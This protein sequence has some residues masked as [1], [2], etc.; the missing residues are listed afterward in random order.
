MEYSIYIT[1]DKSLE[2]DYCLLASNAYD[3]E[4][5]N[6]NI[7]T[8]GKEKI[9][10]KKLNYLSFSERYYNDFITYFSYGRNIVDNAKIIYITNKSKDEKNTKKENRELMKL[11]KT[12]NLTNR[13]LYIDVGMLTLKDEDMDLIQPLAK[14]KNSLVTYGETSYYH[15]IEEL[16]IVNDIVNDI[17]RRLNKTDFSP[18]EKMLYAYDLIR[19]NY[20]INPEY[21]KKMEKALKMYQEPSY[22][23]SFIY[24]EVL[25]RLKIKNIYSYGDFYQASR[26][27]INIAYVKDEY[28][29]IEGIYYFDIADNSKQRVTNSLM[30]LPD[31][32]LRK[33]LINNYE[34]FCKTKNFMVF[35][36][37]LDIDY[38][39]GDFDEEFMQIY[40]YT[41]EHH[42]IKGVYNLRGLLNNVAQ[43]VDGKPVIDTFKGIQS[44]DEL[45]QIRN[46]TQRFVEL[47]SRDIEGEDFLEMLFN[48]R[49]LEY[50]ENKEL[51]PLNIE[52]LK[53]CL[54]KSNFGFS[55]MNLEFDEEQIYEEE[56]IKEKLDESFETCFEESIANTNMEERIRKLK[57]SLNK[58]I[59]KPKKDDNN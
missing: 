57:L 29:D 25:V 1:L 26:R 52:T 18:I 5:V 3:D 41:F 31:D 10:F 44:D 20:M 17:M 15:N 42:G 9:D 38:S 58:D 4:M 11:I 28:Y 59:N 12:N 39:F 24:K 36:G 33:E 37:S 50:M 34:A 30:N 54:A 32:D 40:D 16:E 51:F 27:A 2:R 7:Y 35:N 19:T 43:F 55:K 8:N 14:C 23:Y 6:L 46:D 13:K 21:E 49:A 45:D 47:F 22:L 53:E 56:D 48:V